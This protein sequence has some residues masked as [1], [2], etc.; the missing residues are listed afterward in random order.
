[1]P[2]MDG[3]LD[4]DPA[5]VRPS[6][7]TL[8]LR[9]FRPNVRPDDIRRYFVDRGHAC[10]LVFQ[11][12][13]RG[14]LNVALRFDS[15]EEADQLLKRYGDGRF[16]ILG[17]RPSIVWFKD[18]QAARERVRNDPNLRR[19]LEQRG[20]LPPSSSNY[21]SAV[22]SLS[23]NL[24]NRLGS[25]A[26]RQRRAGGG[27]YD[28]GYQRDEHRDESP[29]PASPKSSH[30]SRSRS[31]LSAGGGSES[32]SKHRPVPPSAPLHRRESPPS[33]I[34]PS[35]NARSR[36]RSPLPEPEA[37]TATAAELVRRRKAD[38]EAM[39]RKDCET[40]ATV[41]KM[42]LRHD[43]SLD[44]PIQLALKAALRDIGNQSVD[45]LRDYI[46]SIQAAS[47]QASNSANDRQLSG[48]ADG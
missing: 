31:V 41:V 48:S 15:H 37:T 10:S 1:R 17:S 40:F 33:P 42:L 14:V 36:S 23:S 26:G 35:A 5:L 21:S 38:I 12:N 9:G 44:G 3:G 46:Q 8:Y 34:S 27:D 47:A 7:H 30:S 19:R 43:P 13:K 16:N 11:V 6:R 18:L 29:P 22:H 20:V 45:E 25:G 39:Y 24:A 32:R 28:S 2:A 4:I